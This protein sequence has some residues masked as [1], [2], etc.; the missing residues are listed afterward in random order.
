MCNTV[1]GA[2]D[3]SMRIKLVYPSATCVYHLLRLRHPFQ[4][5][6]IVVTSVLIF[7]IYFPCARPGIRKECLRNYIV[8]SFI[9]LLRPFGSES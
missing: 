4:V 1:V 6:W 5:I 8:K 9:E 2:D 7:M 3:G